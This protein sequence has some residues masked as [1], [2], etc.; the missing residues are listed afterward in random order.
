MRLARTSSD[1]LRMSRSAPRPPSAAYRLQKFVRRNKGPVIA[2]TLL[3]LAL[4]AGTVGTTIGLIGQSRQRAEA[5]RQAAV[6]Q[7]VG[8]FQLEMLSSADPANLLGD[9]VTVLQAVQSASSEL[10]RGAFERSTHRRSRRSVHAGPHA[11]VV[12]SIG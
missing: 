4:V 8:R 2:A 11:S 10:D 6:A 9:K 5:Q 12:G 7:A 1:I 3:L